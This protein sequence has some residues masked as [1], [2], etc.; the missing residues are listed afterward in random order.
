MQMSGREGAPTPDTVDETQASADMG[1]WSS[2]MTDVGEDLSKQHRAILQEYRQQAPRWGKLEITEHLRWVVDQLPL[3]PQCE[4]VDVA[5]GTGLFGR[6]LAASVASVT[7]VDITPE[8]IEQGRMRVQQDGILNM[9]WQQGTGEKLPFP[10]ERFDLAIT[11]YSVHHFVDPA[12]VLKEM[13]RVC[14]SG[15]MVVAVDMV[16]DEDRLIADRHDALE[17]LLDPTHTSILSPSRFVLAAASGGLIVQAYLSRNVPMNFEQWQAHIPP[18]SESRRAVR[19][20]L[21]AELAGGERTGMNPFMRD[22]ALWFVHIWGVML[23]GKHHRGM[24]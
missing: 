10:D 2:F 20:A 11:R 17:R 4:V 1:R 18:N 14:R 12:L 24:H 5:A 19:R 22:G 7:A 3:S 15:G 9:V 6:A 16:S 13:G 8:M 21:E 23:A